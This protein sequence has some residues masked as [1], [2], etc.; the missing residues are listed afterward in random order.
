LND[1][2][3]SCAPVVCNQRWRSG[4]PLGGLGCGKLELLTD[5]SFGKFTIN[6]NWDRPTGVVRGAFLGLRRDD[7]LTLLRLH[8]PGEYAADAGRA[9]GI[10]HLAN[11]PATESVGLFPRARVRFD[12]LPVEVTL[13]AFCPLIPGNIDDSALPVALLTVTLRSAADT[14]LGLLLSWENLLGVGGRRR[15]PL[16]DRTGNTHTPA[17]VGDWTGLRFHTTPGKPPNVSGEYLVLSDGPTVTPAHWDPRA[18]LVERTLTLAAGQPATV[19]F[20]VAWHMPHHVVQFDKVR[21][22]PDRYVEVDAAAV[23]TSDP[24]AKWTTRPPTL[25]GETL[26]LDLGAARPLDALIVRTTWPQGD[27]TSG[28]TLESS[29]DGRFWEPVPHEREPVRAGTAEFRFAPRT[30]RYYRVTQTGWGP[31]WRWEVAEA[32]GRHG[33]QTLRCVAAVA[34]VHAE[35][36][37]T[38][39]EDLGHWYLNRFA[40]VAA[41]ARYAAGEWARLDAE[42]RAW[43]SLVAESSLPAWLK[44]QLLNHSYPAASNS[45]LTRDG[46]FTV[47]ESP[48]T[49]DGALGTMDQRMASHAFWLMFFPELDRRELELFAACQDRVEPRADGRIPHFCGNA[50]HAL[51]DPNVDYGAT[52]WP[53]LS[54]SWVMQVLK[55]Y[56]WTGD[57]AFLESMWPHVQRAMQWLA[58]CDTDGDAIPEGGSTYDYEHLP[59]GAYIFTASV[60]LG[61][62]RAADEIARVLCA[63]S[64]YGAQFERVQESTLARLYDEERG[65]FIKWCGGDRRVENTF[66][67]A[68]AGDW[69]ARLSGLEPIFPPDICESVLRETLARHARPFRPIPPMEVTPDGRP[70]TNI[71]FVLQHIPYLGC[72]AIYL[73]YVADGLDVVRRVYEAAWEL[74]RSPWDCSLN[75]EAPQGRQSWLL[76][77]MTTTAVWHVLPALAGITFDLA[78]GELHF[79]PRA[80]YHGPLFFPTFWAWLDCEPGQARVRVLRALRPGRFTRVNGTPADLPIEP[81]AVWDLST[82]AALPRPRTAPTRFTVRPPTVRPWTAR[83]VLDEEYDVP[84]IKYAGALDDDPVTCWST[85]RP[86]RPGDWFEVDFGASLTLRGLK[87]YFDPVLGEHPRGLRVAVA[88]EGGD[89]REVAD[90]GSEDELKRRWEDGHLTLPYSATARRVRLTQTGAPEW[91]RW[92][93]HGF[94]IV[95]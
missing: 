75:Y 31:D 18:G 3:W 20:L 13:E 61:A 63:A 90:I 87:L 82:H 38:T 26:T 79:A 15:A 8:R 66:V 52:D 47:L 2:F 36:I 37:V 89:W 67:A 25:P 7:T 45:I 77:Y 55:H 93:I 71:C 80:A 64:S 56:R 88:E 42:T 50:H 62:L 60:Y 91:Q 74:N 92:S 30:A 35:E 23:L 22:Q 29:A 21:K 33:A 70:H 6:H 73:G 16:E 12:G 17:A 59:R 41:V 83:S 43:Q 53:D 58:T 10:A 4:V 68:L 48:V 34:R 5:G 76:T 85:D 11:V 72:E 46:R 28:F 65:C 1:A 57:R 9:A 27:F 24:A 94:D 86:M 19:R 40:D 84:P 95:R 54:C 51:G 78:A 14:R 44:C 39:R 69:L 81:D 32:Y 49:M